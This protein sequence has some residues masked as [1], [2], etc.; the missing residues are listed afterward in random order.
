[1]KKQDPLRFNNPEGMANT[2]VVAWYDD[3]ADRAVHVA[4]P[5]GNH[6]IAAHWFG[7][8]EIASLAPIANDRVKRNAALGGDRIDRVEEAVVW[9]KQFNAVW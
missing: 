6:P 3:F 9:F 5:V 8:V 1:M 2:P 4:A 7:S